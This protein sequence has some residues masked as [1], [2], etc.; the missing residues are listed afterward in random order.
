MRGQCGAVDQFHS[1]GFIFWPNILRLCS[2]W[3]PLSSDC[4]CSC[5]FF[6]SLS[7]PA[8]VALELLQVRPRHRPA[9]W[10]R[11][12]LLDQGAFLCVFQW[13]MLLWFC[14]RGA[15]IPAGGGAASRT[16]YSCWLRGWLKLLKAGSLWTWILES[17]RPFISAKWL[18]S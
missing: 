13:W 7:A 4:I 6:F 15:L 11:Q 10:A 17:G 14:V 8:A 2:S 3:A 12:P 18:A 9:G 1:V 16:S 5:S